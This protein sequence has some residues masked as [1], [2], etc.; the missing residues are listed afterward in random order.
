M[1]SAKL[2]YRHWPSGTAW[3][4][5]L[6]LN[7]EIVFSPD[8]DPFWGLPVELE[9][10]GAM[11]VLCILWSTTAAEL[12]EPIERENMAYV[13]VVREPPSIPGDEAYG[14]YAGK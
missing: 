13:M 4:L 14:P 5:R 11:D 12:T 9:S 7:Y 6:Q 8:V 2:K 3:R 10:T 1:I